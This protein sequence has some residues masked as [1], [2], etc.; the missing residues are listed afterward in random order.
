[1]HTIRF[2]ADRG[3]V[4]DVQRSVGG[5]RLFDAAAVARFEL[6]RTL[7]ELWHRTREHPG[8]PFPAGDGCRGGR[9]P[10]AGIGRGDPD[11]TSAPCRTEHG[12]Q[13]GRHGRGGTDHAQTCAIVGVGAAAGY[14]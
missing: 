13:A 9:H 12:R 7:R 2:W 4:A 14:R 6:V 1:M 10:C 5:Y 3:V 8:D 11:A